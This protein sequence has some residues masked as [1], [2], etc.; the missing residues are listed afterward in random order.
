MA[1]EH[2]AR[3]VVAVEHRIELAVDEG[4]QR[5][6]VLAELGAALLERGQHALA[7]VEHELARRALHLRGGGGGGRRAVLREQQGRGGGQQGRCDHEGD[8]VALHG[9]VSVGDGVSLFSDGLS[10]VSLSCVCCSFCAAGSLPAAAPEAAPALGAPPPNMYLPTIW[11][12]STAGV[13]N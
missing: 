5:A 4:T 7:V 8:Q 6:A 9:V 1:P 13:V 3:G 10:G 12:R 2:L 11:I